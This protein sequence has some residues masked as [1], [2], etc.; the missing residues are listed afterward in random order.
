VSFFYEYKKCPACGSEKVKKIGF[1]SER[2]RYLCK[3]CGKKFQNKKRI[4]EED[5]IWEE[6]VHGKQTYKQT[7]RKTGKST[8]SVQRITDRHF[9][10]HDAVDKT[11]LLFFTVIDFLLYI[12]GAAAVV[13]IVLS[14]TRMVFAAGD[15]E[16]ITS[17][18]KTLL[19]AVLGL[20]VVI[21]SLIIINTVL[22]MFYEGR[23]ME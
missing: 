13:M 17:A 19:C 14:G 22:S 8:R 6:Y 21:L 7:S 20:I 16:Q 12:I 3:D 5:K 9:P 10:Q 11:S 23:G 1:Q 4:R 18:K 2:R 15:E